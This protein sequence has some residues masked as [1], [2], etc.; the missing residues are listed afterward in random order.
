VQLGE[1]SARVGQPSFDQPLAFQPG[2]VLGSWKIKVS[3]DGEPV[4]DRSFLVYDA[5]ARARAREADAGL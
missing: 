2:D 4:I 3:A 1:A 5:A